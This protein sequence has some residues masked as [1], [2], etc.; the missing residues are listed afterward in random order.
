MNITTTTIKSKGCIM[1]LLKEAAL[2]TERADPVPP[3]FKTSG[4]WALDE[5]FSAT[6]A[7]RMIN[8]LVA[9]G[10]WEQVVCRVP[11]VNRRLMALPHYGPK[12]GK[13]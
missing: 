1:G 4:Q 2:N 3:G 13:K 5:G 6:T 12:R 10:K 8:R 9:A 7:N 11:T